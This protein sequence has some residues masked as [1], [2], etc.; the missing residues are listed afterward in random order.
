MIRSCFSSL[1]ERLKDRQTPMFDCS[2]E[3]ELIGDGKGLMHI[4]T[5]IKKR[6][7]F[8]LLTLKA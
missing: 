8:V 6:N 1:S 7:V 2:E 3:N 4:F 5:V